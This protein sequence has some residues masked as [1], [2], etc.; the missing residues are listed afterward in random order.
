MEVRKEYGG[1]KKVLAGAKI[2][3]SLHMT[4]QTGVLIETLH[5]LGAKLRWASCNIYSTQDHAAAAIVKAKTAN[6]FAWKGETL[7]EYWDCTNKMLTWP[8]SDGPDILV[9]DGGDATLLI[10]EGVKAERHFAKTGEF[11]DPD[12]TSNAEF[13]Q[14]LRIIRDGL[15][16]GLTQKW[17][18]MSEKLIGVSEETTTGVARLNQMAAKGELLLRAINVNDSVTKQKFDNIYGCKHSLPD[19]LM[20]ATDVMIAGKEVVVAGYGDVGKG[21]ALAMKACGARVVVTEIDPICALQAAMEGFMVKKLDSVVSTADIFV[22]ATGNKGII[23]KHHMAQMK[24]NAIVGN[25]GHFDNEIDM[26][27]LEAYPGIKKVEIKPQVHRYEF[28]DGHGII[29]LAEGRLLNLGCATGHPSFVMSCS[30]SNQAL[31]QID[32]WENRNTDKYEKGKVYKLPKIL[33]EKVARLHLPALQ[34]ELDDLS[35]EQAD[36]LSIPKEGPFKHEQ[37][38]Y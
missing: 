33:D 18:K 9:D 17:T 12:S 25:I 35:Q 10:H 13:K 4:I 11:P 36:Y 8:D 26:E 5:A 14:V 27:G 20:R 28:P 37:Y 24:N 19:G 30:F 21:C 38:R 6:V 23:M 3:G 32:L 34:A 31:A 2:S 22:T 15:K 1:D 16:A 29:I 7:E